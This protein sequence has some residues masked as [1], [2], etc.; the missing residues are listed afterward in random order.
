MIGRYLSNNNEMY[1]NNFCS[2]RISS[3]E[4]ELSAH[5]KRISDDLNRNNMFL[6]MSITVLISWA[7]VSCS[8]LSPDVPI[9]LS[10]RAYS[11]YKLHGNFLLELS[12]LQC[13]GNTI[14]CI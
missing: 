3:V 1:Y 9:F 13:A 4:Q 10:K 2:R 12:P 6:L 14:L 11:L 5:M 8:F 7:G